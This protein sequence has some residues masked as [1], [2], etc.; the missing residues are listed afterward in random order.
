[1]HGLVWSLSRQEL[2]PIVSNPTLP[3]PSSTRSAMIRWDPVMDFRLVDA[4]WDHE[5]L[6][7]AAADTSHLDIVCP[8]IKQR[9]VSQILERCTPQGIR[10][11]TRF[12][13]DD[14]VAGVSDMSALRALLDRGASIR[15]IR[16]LHSKLYLFGE[17]RAIVTSANLTVAALTRN[18]EFGFVTSDPGVITNCHNYFDSLWSRAGDD[19]ELTRLT[20]WEDRVTRCLASG[21]KPGPGGALG[22][23]GTEVGIHTPPPDLP[24]PL[25]EADR[26]FVKLFG[27]SHRRAERSDTILEEVDRSGCHWACTYPKGKRP[28]QV[29]DGDVMYMGRMV[30]DPNDIVVYGRAIAL[31]HRLERDDATQ[32]DIERRS[33]KTKWPHY[34]RVHHAEFIAGTLRNGVSLYELMDELGADAFASTQRNA[35]RGH[36]NTNPRRAYLQQA[37]VQLSPQGAGYLVREF[38]GAAARFGILTPVVMSTL[39]WPDSTPSGTLAS[40]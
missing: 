28:R 14:F 3:H 30:Q 38:Q 15:G 19:L 39:D 24:S 13:L 23:E 35:R 10:V 12:N 36:G 20:E 29:R 9:A 27:E 4:G 25:A 7:A 34:V 40:D 26:A 8:F 18:L 17:D 33:W 16:N 21:A 31:R 2:R 37:A 5:M 11:V 22:D 6:S 32:A 1:M